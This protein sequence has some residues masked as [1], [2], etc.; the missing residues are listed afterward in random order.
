MDRGGW[1]A[2]GLVP[3]GD[4][5]NRENENSLWAR[6]QSQV[7]QA[8]AQGIDLHRLLSQ[9]LLTPACGLGYLTEE[10]ATRALALL[11]V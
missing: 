8:A 3:T 11:P 5:L 4:E 7:Q 1:L 10:A 6:F 9:A 2:W